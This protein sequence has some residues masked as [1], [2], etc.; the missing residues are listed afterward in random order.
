[1]DDC[2]GI[3]ARGSSD[4]ARIRG[5]RTRIGSL[6]VIA[7]LIW[8]VSAVDAGWQLLPGDG[9]INAEIVF[10]RSATTV[11]SLACGHDLALW[12]RYPGR[13][14]NS[15]AKIIVSNSSASVSIK[16]DLIHDRQGR[17]TFRAVWTGGKYPD[18]GDFDLLISVLASQQELT[19]RAKDGK[20]RLPPIASEMI[21]SYKDDC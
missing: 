3:R 4:C 12:L 6:A 7:Q 9:S 13:K 11:V 20:F 19:F 2:I 18:P 16:G 21:A 8:S 1:L 14:R 5:H 15:H 17:E 10:T